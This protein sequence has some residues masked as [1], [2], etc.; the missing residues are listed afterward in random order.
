MTFPIPLKIEDFSTKAGYEK[1][2]QGDVATAEQIACSAYHQTNSIDSIYLLFLVSIFKNDLESAEILINE[3]ARIAG[4]DQPGHVLFGQG[5]IL[6]HA[7]KKE[8]AIELMKKAKSKDQKSARQKSI[9]ALHLA[10]LQSS[11]QLYSEAMKN[12]DEHLSFFRLQTQDAKDLYAINLIFAQRMDKLK[13]I[14][15]DKKNSEFTILKKE[16]LSTYLRDTEKIR[17]IEPAEE[18]MAVP[19]NI[20]DRPQSSPI[21]WTKPEIYYGEI[22]DAHII[23]GSSFILTKEKALLD[24]HILSENYVVQYLDKGFYASN[25]N[26]YCHR[27]SENSA[28][29]VIEKGIFLA[30]RGSYNYYHWLF[31]YVAKLRILDLINLDK[32]IPIII[33]KQSTIHPQF[34]EILSYLNTENREI[35]TIEPFKKYLVKS[36]TALSPV[37]WWNYQKNGA[38]IYAQDTKSAHFLIEKTKK[39]IDTPIN[40][41]PE[42]I[43]VSRKHI[44]TQR[45]IINDH[46]LERVLRE[47]NFVTAF[48]EKMSVKEQVNLFSNAKILIGDGSGLLNH[49]FSPPGC[50]II[51]LLP[52]EGLANQYNRGFEIAK[53]IGQEI[54]TLECEQEIKSGSSSD[55]DNTIVDIEK[56][57]QIINNFIQC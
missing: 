24:D 48:P 15:C 38:L 45:K 49:I 42:R 44:S 21:S 6:S 41:N 13:T 50:R 5:I 30:G 28:P 54:L 52:K 20:F 17:V 39:L 57:R 1:L 32:T 19:L 36:L 18:Q 14:F 4:K 47:Y 25:K 11:V 9:Y 26:N 51:S 7:G 3:A 56:L 46:E 10:S 16:P 23:G 27:L 2:Q 22:A 12:L 29:T 8:Q 53:S 34:L 33:D 35:I 55:Q 43:Y 37:F 40:K 31:E